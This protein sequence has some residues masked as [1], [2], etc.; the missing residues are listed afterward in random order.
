MQCN[1]CSYPESYYLAK[2]TQMLMA[3]IRSEFPVCAI[4]ANKLREHL[5]F[6]ELLQGELAALKIPETV[7]V[8]G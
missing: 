3:P 5:A 1:L 6:P 2:I 8:H 4:C 7:H